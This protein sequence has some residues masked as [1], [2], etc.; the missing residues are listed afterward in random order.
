MDTRGF[1]WTACFFLITF[2]SLCP[3]ATGWA[4]VERAEL[5]KRLQRFELQWEQ[6]PGEAQVASAQPMQEAVSSFFSLRLLR[7]AEKLDEAWWTARARTPSEAERA[8]LAHRV[9]VST[10]ILNTASLTLTIK[11]EPFYKPSVAIENAEVD[12][13]VTAAPTALPTQRPARLEPI[14]PT[15]RCSWADAVAGVTLDVA[16]L[17]E[18]DYEI[19]TTV[20]LADETLE[21]L[22]T[23]WS[24]IQDGPARLEKLRQATKERETEWSPWVRASLQD[25]ARVMSSMLEGDAQ[26]VDYPAHHWLVCCEKWVAQPENAAALIRE[27]A[28]ERDVWLTV[29]EGRKKVA[30]RVRAPEQVDWGKPVP[31]L[32]LF[33]GAGGSENMFFET[34]GAGG[35]VTAG[36]QRGWLVIA[37]RQALTGLSLDAQQILNAVQPIFPIDQDQVYFLGHSMGAG[38]VA[39][40]VGLHPTLPRAVAAIGGGGRPRQIEAAAK[41]PWFVAAGSLDFGRSGAKSLSQSLQR[42]GGQRIVYREYP[43]VEH[44]VIVQAALGDAFEFFDQT[45]KPRPEVEER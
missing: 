1:K 10:L 31:V 44:M 8:V 2:G 34:Y 30:L 12:F 20:K 38:Q 21:L 19:R 3:A 37:T 16:A 43:N 18:G 15:T 40:Q 13:F 42:A 14:G 36:L 28:R 17:P 5:G 9:A 39:T 33:H 11:L 29:A 32:F 23:G 35:A 4:Q 26:E 22:P 45:V 7:A 24:R 6:S 25:Q 27:T 41:I